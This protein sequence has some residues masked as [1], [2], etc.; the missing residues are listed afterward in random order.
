MGDVDD[1]DGGI[2]GS[3]DLLDLEGAGG[4]KAGVPVHLLEILEVHR[5]AIGG[6]RA[7]VDDLGTPVK[8]SVETRLDDRL[9]RI[10]GERSPAG[11]RR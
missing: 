3:L 8:V 5:G 10:L 2:A 4:A 7:R 9:R 11:Q 6:R 1:G